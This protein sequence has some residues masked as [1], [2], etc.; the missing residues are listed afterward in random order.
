MIN[1]QTN[2]NNAEFILR[3]N[4]E[5]VFPASVDD[6]MTCAEQQDFDQARDIA[7]VTPAECLPWE[8]PAWQR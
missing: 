3:F 8:R 7:H 5:S 1:K 2:K 6:G 4:Q